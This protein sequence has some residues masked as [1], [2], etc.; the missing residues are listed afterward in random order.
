[1]NLPKKIFSAVGLDVRWIKNVRRCEQKNYE[2]KWA[3]SHRFLGNAG[4]RTVLD[5]GANNGQFARMIVR[6]C[7]QLRT[8]HSFEPLADCQQVL[9]NA[10]PGD[11]RH[12]IHN[13]G[14][15][16][17]NQ[18]SFFNHA[19]FSPCSSLLIP[20]SL[21]VEDHPGAGQIKREKVVIRTLDDWAAQNPLE[22]EILIKIDVQG[23]EDRVLLGGIK[24][25]KQSRYIL[26][27]VPFYQL[28]VDQPLFHEVYTILHELG[29][30]YK[31]NTLQNIRSVD[32]RILEADALFENQILAL[33]A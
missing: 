4:I 1:M 31:G 32:G 26:I 22:P 18:T 6:A 20:N 14:L 29:F 11:S 28:Y 10:L 16:D 12:V 33:R 7:P 9:K 15:G 23:Y 27:E 2:E 3:E 24:T 17:T 13:F 25:I 19:E 30:V 21:L 8:L 5:I